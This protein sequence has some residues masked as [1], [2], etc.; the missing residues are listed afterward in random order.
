MEEGDLR[1]CV[2]WQGDS[3]EELHK[4]KISSVDLADAKNFLTKRVPGKKKAKDLGEKLFPNNKGPLTAAQKKDVVKAFRVS[5]LSDPEAIQKEARKIAAHRGSFYRQKAIYCGRVANSNNTYTVPEF[6]KGSM[7]ANPYPVGS[8][9]SGR[10]GVYTL[11]QSLAH[12]KTYLWARAE[13]PDL[14][15]LRKCIEIPTAMEKYLQKALT[16]KP[17]K[18]YNHLRLTGEGALFGA[19]FRA[20][21]MALS[22]KRLGCFCSPLDRCHVDTILEYINTVQP[23]A[24]RGGRSRESSRSRS[25]SPA[26]HKDRRCRS[27]SRSVSVE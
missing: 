21:V 27:R 25:R 12:H 13:V 19:D 20:A 14:D 4:A 1:R 17:G 23:K 8:T 22:G 15:A 6:Q 24:P 3:L 26:A 9:D 16:S 2:A 5:L 11:E 10:T 18:N 7:F